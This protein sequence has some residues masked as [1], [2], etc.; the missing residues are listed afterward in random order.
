MKVPTMASEKG[1]GSSC[2]GAGR[3]EAV[4]ERLVGQVRSKEACSD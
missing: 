3:R 2:L 4:I 1:S